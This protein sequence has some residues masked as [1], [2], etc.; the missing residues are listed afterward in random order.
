MADMPLAV[1]MAASAPS[2]AARRRSNAVTVGL[3]VRL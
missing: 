1:A 3:A 2:S